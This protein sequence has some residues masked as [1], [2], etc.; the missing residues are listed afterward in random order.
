VSLPLIPG[1]SETQ[2]QMNTKLIPGGIAY[3]LL[4]LLL[5]CARTKIIYH[6]CSFKVIVQQ[7]R[8]IQKSI[9][10]TGYLFDVKPC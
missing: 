10:N 6:E 1:T 9:K 3:T 4:K 2:K 5:S 8:T 7:D